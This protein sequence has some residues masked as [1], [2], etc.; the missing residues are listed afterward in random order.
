[1]II[2][3]F[4]SIYLTNDNNFIGKFKMASFNNENETINNQT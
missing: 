1:M 4:S 2:F 3:V